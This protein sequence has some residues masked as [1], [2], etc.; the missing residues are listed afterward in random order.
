[1]RKS[2][3][4]QNHDP[5][6]AHSFEQVSHL[7]SYSAIKTG[8]NHFFPLCSFPLAVCRPPE[9]LRPY[10]DGS[11]SHANRSCPPDFSSGYSMKLA[12]R[13]LGGGGAQNLQSALPTGRR[14]R[15]TLIQNDLHIACCHLNLYLEMLHLRAHAEKQHRHAAARYSMAETNKRGILSFSATVGITGYWVASESSR[16]DRGAR[17]VGGNAPGRDRVRIL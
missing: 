9:N 16:P 17:V 1:M 15:I 8:K 12:G 6:Q 10:P 3:S 13:G 2:D 4:S 11:P 14:L 7:W 5:P